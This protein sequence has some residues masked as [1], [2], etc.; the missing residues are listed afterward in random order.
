MTARALAAVWGAAI[1][2]AFAAILVLVQAA[3][4]VPPPFPP[5]TELI[6]IGSSLTRNAIPFDPVPGGILGDGRLH[7]RWSISSIDE[8]RTLD[9]LQRALGTPAQVIFVEAN[10]LTTDTRAESAEKA[11]GIAG[12]LNS[13]IR[14]FSTTLRDGLKNLEGQPDFTVNTG[15]PDLSSI[16]WQVTPKLRR[17]QMPDEFR[18]P[19]D[20]Q[21]LADLLARAKSLGKDVIFYEPP[22]SDAMISAM[23]VEKT[24]EFLTNTSRVAAELGV[25]LIQ[26]GPAWPDALFRDPVHLNRNGRVRFLAE[27]PEKVKAARP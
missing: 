21:R 20:R 10:A 5:Q 14:D 23:G 1:V 12:Q 26:F 17:V 18:E 8:P 27:L 2:L 6:F 16:A 19:D 3:Q 15:E 9:M 22:R 13:T 25:P 4:R 24:K 11:Q 7:A